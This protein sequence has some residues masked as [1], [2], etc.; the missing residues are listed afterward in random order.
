MA[1]SSLCIHFQ[2]IYINSL[3]YFQGSSL[4]CHLRLVASGVSLIL[5][6]DKIAIN[7]N[8]NF[9]FPQL[10]VSILYFDFKTF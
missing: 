10:V 1:S 7:G 8:Y 2:S 9:I 4:N 3:P 5:I 6:K